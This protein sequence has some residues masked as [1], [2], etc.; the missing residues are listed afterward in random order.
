MDDPI[1]GLR[2]LMGRTYGLINHEWQ[3]NKFNK[4]I[5]SLTNFNPLI[6]CLTEKGKEWIIPNL[7]KECI[8]EIDTYSP[9][10]LSIKRRCMSEWLAVRVE[11]EKR[12]AAKYG[13]QKCFPLLDEKI[14]G[15]LLNQDPKY[16]AEK[17]RSWRK[18]IIKLNNESAVLNPQSKL[19][20]QAKCSIVSRGKFLLVRKGTKVQIVK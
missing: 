14:I 7:A 3:E 6:E 15:T 1:K 5:T 8:D 18:E 17:L 11:E 16:F 10:H 4:K 20:P 19:L 9:L 12:L 2:T 13:I